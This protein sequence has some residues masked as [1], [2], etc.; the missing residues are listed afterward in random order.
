MESVLNRSDEDTPYT[1]KNRDV[2]KAFYGITFEILG[3]DEDKK[4][5]AAE[6]GIGIDDIILKNKVVDW[7]LKQDTQNKMMNEI[8]DYLADH[9]KIDIDYDSIDLIME[10]C[11]NVAKH[12]YQ[13]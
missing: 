9:E 3:E 12:R 7:Y 2:A 4:E 13:S 1:L 5:L 8:E 6:I 10:K 11:I